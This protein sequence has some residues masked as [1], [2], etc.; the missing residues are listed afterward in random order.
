MEAIILAG[1]LGTRLKGVVKDIPKPMADINGKPFLLYLLEYLSKFQLN[2]IV[3]SVGYKYEVIE[4]YFGNNYKNIE[5]IYAVENEPLG[6]GGGIMNAA[7][8]LQSNLFF[9][10]NG[11]SFFN[12]NLD[13]LVDFHTKQQADFTLSVKKMKDFDR[14]GSVEIIENRIVQFNEKKYMPEGFINAGVYLLNKNLLSN[15]NFPLKFS[16]EKAFLETF[17]NDYKFAAFNAE[18]YFIDIGIP[19]DYLRANHELEHFI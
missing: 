11:D 2:R 9:L 6:T 1:G 7:K 19:E 12:V 14:Y 8:F 4:S 3:L 5:L 16:F 17:L 15:L 13:E 10:I 18:G